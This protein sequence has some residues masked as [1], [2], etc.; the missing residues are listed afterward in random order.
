MKVS[1]RELAKT[2]TRQLM[3]GQDLERLSLQ[4]AAYLVEHKMVSQ[5]DR[6]IQD[7]SAELQAATGQATATVVTAFSPSSHNLQ[8]LQTNLKRLLGV[9][10]VELQLVED[11]SLL[12]GLVVKLPGLEMDASVRQKLRVLARG[13][14]A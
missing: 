11:K 12:G 3:A 10:E 14:S 4:V 2:V 9:K 7:V 13:G 5:A 1:R 8:T 6:L